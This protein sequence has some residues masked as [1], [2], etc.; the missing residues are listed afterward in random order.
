[1]KIQIEADLGKTWS[2]AKLPVYSLLAA[3][4]L[5]GMFYFGRATK[6]E[7]HYVVEV[8]RDNGRNELVEGRIPITL[9]RI[10]ERIG[11]NSIYDD[12]GLMHGRIYEVWPS[13]KEKDLKKQEMN[14]R[15]AEV[16]ENG[17][18]LIHNI[19]VI[20]RDEI[21]GKSPSHNTFGTSNKRNH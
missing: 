5:A 19:E 18:L 4:C 12:D 11:K 14:L 17:K 16:E 20:V 10:F 7:K 15:K 1:M 21:F 9:V 6:P 2:R 13:M 3:S 8:R